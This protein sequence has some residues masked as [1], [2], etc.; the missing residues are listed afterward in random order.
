MERNDIKKQLYREKPIA[1]Y[2]MST[3]NGLVLYR[4][5]VGNVSVLFKIPYKESVGFEK[6]MPAQLLIRWM[7]W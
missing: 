5:K 4:T 3:D 6:E 2:V 7:E 1:N